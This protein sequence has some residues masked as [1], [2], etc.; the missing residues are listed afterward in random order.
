MGQSPA[1]HGNLSLRRIIGFACNQGF[2][3]FLFYMGTNRSYSI[4]DFSFERAELFGALFFMVVVFAI[5]RLISPKTRNA[6]LMRPLLIVYAIMGVIGSFIPVFLDSASAFWIPIEGALI[7]IPCALLLMSWGR[8]FGESSTKVSVPEVFFGSVIGALVGLIVSLIPIDGV[9]YVLHLLPIVSAAALMAAPQSDAETASTSVVEASSTVLLSAKII[10]GTALFGMAAGFME[11]FNTNPGN[12]AM[13][14]YPVSLLL[15]GA[16]ALGTLSLLRSDGFGRGAALNK[17]YRLALFIMMTGY[18]LIPVPQF[19]ESLVPGE[20]IVLAGY[21]GLS[22]VLISLFLVLA[23]LTGSDTAASFSKGFVALFGGELIGVALA[24]AFDYAQPDYVTPYSVVV[25]A[26][27]LVLFSYVFL[28]T[29]RDFENLSEIVTSTDSLEDACSAI[30]VEYGLSG[31]EAEILPFALRGR[32]SDR[33]SQELHISKS[34]VDTH[35]R[36]IY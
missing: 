27:L 18:L 33:I 13:A 2:V 15:F 19:A 10:A 5:L 34:T 6:L 28:F 3:F 31:R 14:A 35:L 12:P 32:T 29:E 23:K 11:T 4:G 26:G 21:L 24:N 36:R 9:T 30:A 17:A 7:G 8:A 16:F 22:A 1:T 20:A 25:F